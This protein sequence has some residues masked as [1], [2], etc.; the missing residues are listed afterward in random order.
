M[1][2]HLWV[3]LVAVSVAGWSS[4]PALQQLSLQSLGPPAIWILLVIY[5]AA[6]STLILTYST[7]RLLTSEHQVVVTRR[8]IWHGLRFGFSSVVPAWC[9]PLAMAFGPGPMVVAP[10]GYGLIPIANVLVCLIFDR[11]RTETPKLSF[12]G[13]VACLISG[14]LTTLINRPPPPGHAETK[15]IFGI[16]L[17]FFVV[18]VTCWGFFGTAQQA[19]IESNGNEPLWCMLFLGISYFTVTSIGA[20][21]LFVLFGLK[22][23]LIS[24]TWSYTGVGWGVVAGMTAATGTIC[25]IYAARLARNPMVLSTVQFGSAPVFGVLIT[26]LVIKPRPPVPALFL[27]GIAVVSLAVVSVVRFRPRV[28]QRKS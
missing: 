9:F 15:V 19:A 2:N 13:A 3:P 5:G 28:I 18:M 23:G 7:I 27:V 21:T 14:V 26:Y 11:Q 20:I 17:L 8:G 24:V 1:K 4:Y 16:W 22:P 6:Y 12:Y 25:S 10:M